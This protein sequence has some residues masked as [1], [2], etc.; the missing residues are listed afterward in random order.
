MRVRHRNSVSDWRRVTGCLLDGARL[1]QLVSVGE[2]LEA[3]RGGL[4]S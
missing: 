1:R 4:A 3:G 2:A